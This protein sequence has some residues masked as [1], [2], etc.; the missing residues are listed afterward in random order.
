MNRPDGNQ[1]NLRSAAYEAVMEMIK[2]CPMVGLF[3][4]C[5]LLMNREEGRRGQEGGRR[6]QERGRRGEGGQ[7]GCRG[8]QESKKPQRDT[9]K[10]MKMLEFSLT[11]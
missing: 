3:T 2:N 8:V 10:Q 7:E 9:D 6:G 5:R 1:A 11:N 4:I